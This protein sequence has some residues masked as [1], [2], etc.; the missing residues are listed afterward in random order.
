MKRKHV[1]SGAISADSIDFLRSP[2]GM[3]ALDSLSDTDL[4]PAIAPSVIARLRRSLEPGEAG[5]VL[6]LAMLRRK[7]LAKFP[8]AGQMF[9]TA[10]ALEQSTAAEVA[11]H[12]ALR[13]DRLAPPGVILDLGCGIGGDALAIARC[14]DVVAFE[15]D[16]TRA[17]IARANA[18]ALGLSHQLRVIEDDWVDVFHSG[19]LPSAS[20]AFVDPARRK[21]GSRIKDLSAME[22]PIEVIESLRAQ[23]P[24]I[25]L[26]TR[27]GL[28]DTDLPVGSAVEFVGHAGSCKEAVIWMGDFLDGPTRWASIHDGA[29]WHT[30]NVI[31]ARAP[32]GPVRPGDRLVEPHPAVIRAGAVAELGERLGAHLVDEQIAYLIVPEGAPIVEHRLFGRAFRVEEVFPFALR[33]LNVRLRA[34]G[35]G[36]VELKKRGAPFEPESM[37]SRLK[38]VKGGN[39]AVIFFTRRGDERIVLIAHRDDVAET[40]GIAL[41][42]NDG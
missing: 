27:P 18:E 12:R 10:E 37:R 7:A 13:I 33:H 25:C 2:A 39:Q 8:D 26:K 3:Q 35:I 9:F 28:D 22:P 20:A 23:L 21:G 34:L 4:H 24:T 42:S 41:S 19:S 30:I 5:A 40:R 15:R 14:R 38:L 29:A 1:V 32:V 31:G 17:A 11:E 6:T 36:S 16:P